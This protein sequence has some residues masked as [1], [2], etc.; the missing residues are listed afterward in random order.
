MRGV[1]KVDD[2]QCRAPIAE[3]QKCMHKWFTTLRCGPRA[4]SS[5]YFSH[6]YRERNKVA[7]AIATAPIE[8]KSSCLYTGGALISDRSPVPGQLHAQF[9][10]GSRAGLAGAGW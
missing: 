5:D 10:G 9:D 4:P 3:A 7:D 6:C 2:N 1:W 8:R